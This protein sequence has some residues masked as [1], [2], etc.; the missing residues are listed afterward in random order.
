MPRKLPW[1]VDDCDTKEIK[2]SDS[3]SNASEDLSRREASRKAVGRNEEFDIAEDNNTRIVD[4][5]RSCEF[6]A[7][8]SD[9]NGSSKFV[10]N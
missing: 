8:L 7:S 2:K 9:L 1:L 6:N 10:L 4:F 3:K 5:L